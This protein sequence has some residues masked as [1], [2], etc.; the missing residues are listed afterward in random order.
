M[1]TDQ[2]DIAPSAKRREVFGESHEEVSCIPSRTT[3]EADFRTMCVLS[4]T[5]K[6]SSE[7]I[8]YYFG[9]VWPLSETKGG[10]A[11]FVHGRCRMAIDPRIPT[12]P[13]R[14]TSG[15][16]RLGRHCLHQTRSAVRR[17]TSRM[18]ESGEI[19]TIEGRENVEI[20]IK[21]LVNGITGI[22][23]SVLSLYHS[24]SPR[25]I[26]WRT[27]SLLAT[28]A[29]QGQPSAPSP[30]PVHT[31]QNKHRTEELAQE[32]NGP[33]IGRP[34]DAFLSELLIGRKTCRPTLLRV[35][36]IIAK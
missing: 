29:E 15:F 19:T 6:A 17:L 31:Y 35:V 36:P 28:P 34:T 25:P 8:Y 14:S 32:K 3:C 22:A 27:S 16:H 20:E 4:R 33:P 7:F 21:H 5:S 23:P 26:C 30:P 10:C 9:V 12:M 18:K 1:F 24:V 2:A 11:R 13:G